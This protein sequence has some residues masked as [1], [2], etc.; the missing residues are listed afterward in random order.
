MSK[1][2]DLLL[3]ATVRK[4]GPWDDELEQP[5]LGVMLHYTAGTD[6]SG[7]QWLLFDPKCKVSYNWLGLDDGTVVSVA[8][9]DVRAYHA[10]VCRPSDLIRT[11]TRG[12]GYTDANSAFY[13]YAIAAEDGDRATPQQLS[14]CVQTIVGLFRTHQWTP[15][16]ARWRITDHAAEAWPRGRKSDT[17]AVL[18]LESVRQRVIDALLRLAVA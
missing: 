1:L 15:E 5:R 7:L 2:S 16:Q 6:L 4:T 10:G 12:A 9:A 3:R 11:A 13:G 17:G 18:P 14:M 8:P